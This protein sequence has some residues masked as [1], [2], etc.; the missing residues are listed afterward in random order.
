MGKIR[1]ISADI[2]FS[3]LKWYIICVKKFVYNGGLNE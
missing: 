1:I 2:V 3:V